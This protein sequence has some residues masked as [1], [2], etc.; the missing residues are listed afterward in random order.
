MLKDVKP[1]KMRKSLQNK[2][3]LY[4]KTFRGATTEEMKDYVRPSLKYNPDLIILHTGTNDLRSKLQ[5]S[6]IADDIMK[7]A[8]N[9]KCDEND[10]A[11]S[12]IIM[13]NDDLNERGKPF[14]KNKMFRVQYGLY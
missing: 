7:L 2:E 3:K 11:V 6:Q 8:L 5:P 13:R 4:V 12:S 10:V 14:I 9:M 1:F